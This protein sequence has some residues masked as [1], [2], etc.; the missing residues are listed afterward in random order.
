MYGAL[1]LFPPWGPIPTMG[2]SRYFVTFVDDYSQYTWLY[3]LQNRSELPKIYSG[4]QKMVQTQF[5]QNIKIFRFDNAMEYHESTF[6]STLKQNG[7]LPHV[8]G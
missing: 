6:L 4:F 8:I 1:N 7:T 2:G 5:S 3:L